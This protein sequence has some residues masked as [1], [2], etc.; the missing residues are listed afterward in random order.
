MTKI[1]RFENIEVCN[2]GLVGYVYALDLW[3][4]LEGLLATFCIC[5]TISADEMRLEK[6]IQAFT[7]AET[8]KND[9]GPHLIVCPASL[10]ENWEREL[11]KWCPP[12]S[13]LQYHG[14]GRQLTQKS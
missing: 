6:T 8:S 11:K 3:C 7:F 14:A 10:W 2:L 12:F 9:C 4:N 13:V 1:F 5:A